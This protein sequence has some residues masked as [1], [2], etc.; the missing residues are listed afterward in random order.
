[1][2]F[3]F[4][5]QLMS[6]GPAPRDAG[7]H[8][9]D[10]VALLDELEVD[11]AHLVSTSFGGA[12][13]TMVAARRPDRVRSL[14]SI[15]SADGFDD[16]MADEVARWRPG[17][18]RLAGG[19]RPG[20]ISDVLEPVVY[21]AAYLATHRDERAQ[22][23]RQIAALP[24]GWF[25]GLSGCSTRPPSVALAGE[26]GSGS[27]A[28]R[29]SWPPSS[30][31]S[32]RWRARERWPTGSRGLA[33]RSSRAPVT[34]WS[35]SSTGASSRCASSFLPVSESKVKS[36]KSKVPESARA[37]RARGAKTAHTARRSVYSGRNETG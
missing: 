18:R 27:A 17:L 25:E 20:L 22:R 28:R 15:A 5:G 36:Q 8:V 23:R 26:L 24:E 32:S 37:L 10:V 21:S 29:W 16:V 1:M 31:G 13:A 14:I 35:S 34:R 7:E 11:R 3:D 30:T 33:S 12:V 2:R 9:D 4:R 6:P 19:R